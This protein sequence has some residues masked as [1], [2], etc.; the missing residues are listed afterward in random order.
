[1]AVSTLRQQQRQRQ[2]KCLTDPKFWIIITSSIGICLLIGLISSTG[3]LLQINDAYSIT[4]TA[5]TADN[6][7]II[8]LDK[9]QRPPP[10]HDSNRA[11]YTEF[12]DDI[13]LD[14]IYY[15]NLKTNKK[16]KEYTE[17]WLGKS[18]NDPQYSIYTHNTTF[19]RFEALVGEEKSCISGIKRD[20]TKRCIGLSGLGKTLVSLIDTYYDT[21]KNGFTFILEDDYK[22]LNW[23][24]LLDS[25]KMVP[26]KHWD[27]IRFDC[28]GLLPSIFTK[29]Y[30]T[31]VKLDGKI[32]NDTIKRERFPIIGNN[33]VF[34]SSIYLNNYTKQRQY[35]KESK[36]ICWFCGG[37]YAM[38]W[39]GTSI[40]KIR[41]MWSTSTLQNQN[42]IK[43]KNKQSSVTVDATSGNIQKHYN[44]PHEDV[45]CLISMTPN[46]N[47]YCIQK[48]GIGEFFHP[49]GEGSNIQVNK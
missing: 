44:L 31:S 17:S 34:R 18:L 9:Q 20:Q 27:I 2:T 15:I 1:M 22:I 26:D 32:S 47:P 23:T 7:N 10:Q 12:A 28:N 42:Y 5:A 37:T 19:H 38:L 4:T 13:I 14:R 3:N 25:I 46:I 36:E 16:R 48:E 35:C 40:D 41:N 24:L 39:K 21:I 8:S 45:D 11:E 49:P 6:N 33:I 43:N 30:N 29:Y